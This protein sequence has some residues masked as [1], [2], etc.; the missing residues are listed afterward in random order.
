MT[1]LGV[2]MA[3]TCMAILTQAACSKA[4]EKLPTYG[5]LPAFTMQNQRGETF[6]TDQLSGKISIVNF[7]FTRCET[8][9][10]AFTMKMKRVQDR[11][12]KL[13]EDLQLEH[14]FT[15]ARGS[16]DVAPVVIASLE[17][18]GIVGPQFD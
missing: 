4:Q 14:T 8:V 9:C 17:H 6:K 7:M 16:Q 13:G 18:D 11:T 15:I 5:S 10:P 12:A 2:A 3:T 1:R